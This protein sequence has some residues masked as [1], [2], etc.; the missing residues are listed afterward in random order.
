MRASKGREM[1]MVVPV[2]DRD[3]MI[4]IGDQGVLMADGT[5]KFREFQVP[6]E[7]HNSIPAGASIRVVG[8]TK[9]RA[10]GCVAV[11]ERP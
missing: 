2:M 11:I 5:G 10:S 4:S 9:D 1:V 3:C 6:V 8:F 7:F